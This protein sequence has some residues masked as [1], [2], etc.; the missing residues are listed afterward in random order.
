MSEDVLRDIR[1]SLAKAV[2][3]AAGH[4]RR[5]R[6]PALEAAA[7]VIDDSEILRQGFVAEAEA[8][9]ARVHSPADESEAMDIVLHI[10]REC[11]AKV[12]LAW[13][14]AHLPIPGI[15]GKLLDAGVRVLDA[16]LPDDKAG[17]AACLAEFDQALVGITGALAGLADTGSLALISGPGRGRLASLLPPVHIALLPASNLYPNMA[18]FFAD[19]PD[20]V[21]GAGNLVFIS[22]PS[23]TADI[24]QTLTLGVHGPRELHV[25]VTPS[26]EEAGG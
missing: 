7:R 25:V 18:A 9:S 3:P 6:S 13:D 21:R 8:L 11:E 2:L 24:E 15:P 20:V 5:H 1:D 19:H 22:G 23:R 14:E 16:W 26:S 10:V 4:E 17:R 12:V